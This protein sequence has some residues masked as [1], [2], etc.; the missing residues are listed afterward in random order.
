M[1]VVKGP[2]G[3]YGAQEGKKF[4][5][6]EGTI[7]SKAARR[8]ELQLFK[9]LVHTKEDNYMGL[10]NP[11]YIPYSEKDRFIRFKKRAKRPIYFQVDENFTEGVLVFDGE[12]IGRI[13]LQDDGVTAELLPLEE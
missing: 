12:G 9:M 6:L 5:I 13:R 3:F 2:S 4:L 1:D 11:S 10:A 7:Y 8:V